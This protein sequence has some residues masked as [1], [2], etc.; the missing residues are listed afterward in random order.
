VLQK[1][2]QQT[3]SLSFRVLLSLSRSLISLCVSL[4]LLVTVSLSQCWSQA[5]SFRIPLAA[6]D[7]SF[8]RSAFAFSV[9]AHQWIDP[10]RAREGVVS[11]V[12]A[13]SHSFTQSLTH[14]YTYP[15]TYMYTHTHTHTRTHTHTHTPHAGLH[16]PTNLVDCKLPGF[17]ELAG[18][19]VLHVNHLIPIRTCVCKKRLPSVVCHKM[20]N[21]AQTES[22][23]LT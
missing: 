4:C 20:S 1:Q 19:T 14:A 17:R 12:L 15:C 3:K 16:F 22:L 9:C 18:K 13:L 10:V 21:V 8:V 11:Y 23:R 6:A 5:V 7:D 2:P